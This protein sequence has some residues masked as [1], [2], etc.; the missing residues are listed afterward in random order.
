MRRAM[1]TI[2]AGRESF[3]ACWTYITCEKAPLER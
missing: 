1:E 2:F 3:N